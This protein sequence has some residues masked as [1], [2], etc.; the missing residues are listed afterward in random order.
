MVALLVFHCFIKVYSIKK[1]ADIQRLMNLY[2]GAGGSRTKTNMH[3]YIN[4]LH[5]TLF[6]TPMKNPISPT[7]SIQRPYAMQNYEK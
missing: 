4:K 7:Y 1:T 3:L 2:R 5:S 6:Y